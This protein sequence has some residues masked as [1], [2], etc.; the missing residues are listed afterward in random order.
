MLCFARKAAGKSP[1]AQPAAPAAPAVSN[2]VVL[3]DSATDGS[4][5]NEVIELSAAAL[6]LAG[7]SWTEVAGRFTRGAALSRRD[8]RSAL[9]ASA[10]AAFIEW[11]AGL[12]AGADGAE[13]VM[14]AHNGPDYDWLHLQR[15]FELHAQ[16]RCR[17]RRCCCELRR[18]RGHGQR[19]ASAERRQSVAAAAV[20]A[21]Q[22]LPP[23]VVGLGDSGPLFVQGIEAKL[24]GRWNLQE[25]TAVRFDEALCKKGN[26]KGDVSAMLRN[27][28]DVAGKIGAKATRDVIF[29]ACRCQPQPYYAAKLAAVDARRARRATPGAAAATGW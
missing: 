12:S 23:C 11:V 15:H 2:I 27:F 22:V 5:S 1:A 26:T 3:L 29:G 28:Q 25:V 20:A 6:A 16:A 21:A 9:D 13:I 18:P 19:S 24:G 10:T 7:D 8:K 4:S 17:R 14:L